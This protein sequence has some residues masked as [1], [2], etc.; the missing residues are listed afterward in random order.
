VRDPSKFF[1]GADIHD[2]V[3]SEPIAW[4]AVHAVHHALDMRKREFGA[5]RVHGLR[6]APGMERSVASLRSARVYRQKP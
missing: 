5:L 1:V 6:N 2:K 3:M 4:P